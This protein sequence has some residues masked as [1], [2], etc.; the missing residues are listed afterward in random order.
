MTR[1]PTTRTLI[2]AKA[3]C[4][5]C[6]WKVDAANAQALAAQHFDKKGHRIEV[7]V[8]TE[9]IYG[10]LSGKTRADGAQGALL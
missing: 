3:E 10:R 4:Q 7:T 8:T 1:R 2:S 6:A 9:I 5:R